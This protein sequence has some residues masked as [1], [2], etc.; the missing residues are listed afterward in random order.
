MRLPFFFLLIMSMSLFSH[1]EDKL[2]LSPEEKALLEQTNQARQAEK[3]P[4]LVADPKLF[5]AARFHAQQMAKQNQLE[6]TLGDS[7]LVKRVKDTG[8]R[9]RAIAE[10]IAFN[11]QKPAEVVKDWL[12]SEGHRKNLLHPDYT[13]IGVAIAKNEKGERYWVQ[14]FGTPL[15]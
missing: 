15:K 10:N 3:L 13:E 6:H 12:N 5:A 8:Y 7:D 1:G 11:Q 9:Y 14:V 4:P 2:E